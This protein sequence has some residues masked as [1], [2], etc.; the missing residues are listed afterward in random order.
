MRSCPD[1]SKALMQ[2]LL[3]HGLFRY[4]LKLLFLSIYINLYFTKDVDWLV[5]QSDTFYMHM[6]AFIFHKHGVPIL[7]QYFDLILCLFHKNCSSAVLSSYTYIGMPSKTKQCS[8]ASVENVG[9][10]LI[11]RRVRSP[12]PLIDSDSSILCT[13]ISTM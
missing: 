5:S 13:I 4:I 10:L 3:Y 7:L 11:D 2:A 9:W 1:V 6:Y 8:S 12:A